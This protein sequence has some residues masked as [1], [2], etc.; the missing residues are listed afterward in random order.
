MIPE[1]GEFGG[2]RLPGVIHEALQVPEGVATDECDA[3]GVPTCTVEK[4]LGLQLRTRPL[5]F[6]RGED[7]IMDV[8][9]STFAETMEEVFKP[10]STRERGEEENRG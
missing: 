8:G 7:P 5:R 10:Q 4:F 3:R 2:R 1:V 6:L 9:T